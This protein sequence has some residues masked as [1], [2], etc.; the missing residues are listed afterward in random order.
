MQDVVDICIEKLKTDH[1]EILKQIIG[2][3]I[4]EGL[5]NTFHIRESIEST[6]RNTIYNM[7]MEQQNNMR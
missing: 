6:V 1:M 5:T 7:Q 2:D 4:I 3:A